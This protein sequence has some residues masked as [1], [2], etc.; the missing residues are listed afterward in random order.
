[1]L[2]DKYILLNKIQYPAD[3]KRLEVSQLPDLCKE[4]RQYIIEVVSN[5]PGHLGS[6]L[7]T[8][9]LTVALHYVFSLPKDKLVWDVGHQAYAHKI[10]TGR[11]DAFVNNRKYHGISGF[12]KM[13]ESEYDSFGAGH[14]SISISAALGMATAAYLS[15]DTQRQHIAV[16]GDGAL[17][18]GEAFEGLNNSGIA[19]A[20]MLVVLNDNGMAIDQSVGA[21]SRYLLRITTSQT[22][23]RFKNKAWNFFRGNLRRIG[24]NISNILKSSILKQ[25]NL[26]ESFGF[27]YFGPVDG[28][29]V[30]HLVKVLE[31]IKRLKG[32]KLLHCITTKGKGL[33]MA[34]SHQAVYHAPGK[35]D[36]VSGVILPAPVE[37]EQREK[38]QT[39]FGKTICELAAENDK[40]VGIT[41]AMLSGSSLDIMQEKFPDRVFDVG[42]T[43]Q[44]AVTFSAGL[45]VGGYL[46]FCAIYSTFLQRAY[47]QIIHDVALQK[48][49]VIFCID[50]AGLVGEDGATHHGLFDLAYLRCIPN[51]IVSSPLNECEL[52]NLLHTAVQVRKPFAIRYP[53]G[54]GVQP[55]WASHPVQ[56]LEVGKGRC[57]REG[58]EIAL[59]SIGP[60]GN[61]ALE[62]A[63]VLEREGIQ[64]GVYDI[65]FLKP[66]DEALLE[67]I[68]QHYQYLITIENGTKVGG[69]GSAVAE[70]LTARHYSIPL[71]IMGVDDYFVEQGSVAELEAECGLDVESIQKA[72]RAVHKAL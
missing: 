59:I 32:P 1:M 18:G 10:L 24:Q 26:F 44:H 45:A 27:R 69:L 20:N 6:S 38:Y 12:P 25:S 35:F 43:E 30:V 19:N 67:E 4:I 54:K 36:P 11:R 14:A 70:F 62:A 47:D 37:R 33:S 65:C 28:H 56:L 41:P 23:N 16:I 52:R 61:H 63:T 64:V 3:L 8:V 34:E 68:C 71:H 21:M 22:Y 57:L 15:G 7:G 66:L 51:M 49:P 39:V 17:T 29:D 55:D 9:E 48:L 40:I 42:I 2:S 50:R 46:P 72:V 5:N 60:I 31:D 53:R 13:S 58:A